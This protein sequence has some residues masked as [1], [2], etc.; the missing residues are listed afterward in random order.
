VPT[1]V[2]AKDSNFLVPNGTFL[3]ELVA[4]LIIL[5]VIGRFVVPPIQ[6]A[7]RRRREVIGGQFEEARQA[8]ERAEAAEAAYHQAMSEARAEAS[9]IREDARARGQQIIDELKATAQQEADRTAAEGRRQLAESREALVPQL[10]AETGTL[11]VELAGR[12]VGESLAEE[13]RQSGIVEQFIDELDHRS[14]ES[15]ATA[16]QQR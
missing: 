15:T 11:G 1:T 7:M 4:F 6:G 3:V 13:A 5:A 16:G 8:R 10:R 9:Q 2:L 14:G 12:I